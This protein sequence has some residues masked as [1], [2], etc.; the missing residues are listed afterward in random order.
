MLRNPFRLRA[1]E[2]ATREDHFLS[3]VGPFVLEILP[4]DQLWDRLVIIESA[5]GAGKTTILRLFTP[6]S[7]TSLQRSADQEAYRDLSTQLTLLEVI[8]P[9]GPTVS[10][11]LVNCRD[12]YSTIQDLPI[13]PPSQI[14]WFFGLLNARITLLT[15]RSVLT[16]HGLEYPTDVAHLT[17]RPRETST[18]ITEPITGTEMY[19]RASK[20]ERLLTASLNSLV[21]VTNVSEYTLTGLSI[22]RL[23]STCDLYLSGTLLRERI[24]VMF[25]D[26]HELTSDQRH[27][28]RRDLED[29][30]LAIGRW[31]AQRSQALSNVE[32]LESAR[33]K[34]RDFEHVHIEEWAQGN[35]RTGKRFFQLLD[36]VG[37]RRT[38]KAQID[39]DS[40]ESCLNT[41]LTSRE[42]TKAISAADRVERR[43][44]KLAKGQQRF[45]E[46]I[47]REKEEIEELR[48][49]YSIAVRWRKLL[50]MMQF[51]LGKGQLALD[52]PIPLTE[53]E[54]RSPPA[55]N[56]AAGLFLAKEYGLP[57]YF[58]SKRIKLLSSWNIEQYLRLAGDLFDQVL[59]SVAVS[60]NGTTQLTPT[61]QDSVVRIVSRE[62]LSAL[63]TEV[64]YGPDVQRLVESI[65]EFCQK[66][67]HR[68][69]A[70]YAPG[71]TGVGI[72]KLETRLLSAA[73]HHDSG[74]PL[75]RLSRALASAIANNVLEVRHD[76]N[77]KGGR[78]TVFHLNR[79][80]CPVF[81]LPLS[82]GGYKENVGINELML[83]VAG[84]PRP[85]LN[86]RT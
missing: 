58:G 66:Q 11:V 41:E 47:A 8:K 55:M 17:V 40:F 56:S 29:R 6:L 51:R 7:L 35:R 67:T 1:S 59:A 28:L 19:E 68:P 70:P 10:G 76:V 23:L 50:I 31:L 78:W 60:R 25:D 81:N 57:F 2:Q 13:D 39:I 72:S 20:A 5:P 4:A 62:R 52:I 22:L 30:D 83:W 44:Y 42:R 9:Q 73:A 32:L 36:E 61:Q 45:A 38:Q 18:T 84:G 49:P 37:D 33:T 34:G 53:L 71:M 24:L 74:D 16:L 77:V 79:I 64:P 26:A 14:R 65:G 69:T 46:W 80:Y 3:L 85:E 48:D 21:G 27:A 12:Q 54:S 43:V 15:I 75:D 86:L 82:Y 63:T